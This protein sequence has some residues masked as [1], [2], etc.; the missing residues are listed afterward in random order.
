MGT[1]TPAYQPSCGKVLPS[2]QRIPI[3]G[4]ENTILPS[5]LEKFAKNSEKRIPIHGDEN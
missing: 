2:E 5:F 3:H 1:K 4:D